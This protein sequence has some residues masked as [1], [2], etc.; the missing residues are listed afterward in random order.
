MLYKRR[1]ERE[2]KEK[3]SH[4]NYKKK[5]RYKIDN[6]YQKAEIKNLEIQSR[7]W[8]FKNTKLK[9]RREKK[10]KKKGKGKQSHKNYKK[11]YL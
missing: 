5:Y 10:R 2:K 4:K 1:R 11:K 9:K 6:R 3:K 7:V 8:N